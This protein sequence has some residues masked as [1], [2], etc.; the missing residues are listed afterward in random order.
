MKNIL[1][2]KIGFLC[3]V[4]GF[5]L[6]INTPKAS[7]A[8]C[9]G[10]QPQCDG[11]CVNPS[12]V[13]APDSYDSMGVPMTCH[14][15]LKQCFETVPRCDGDCP[16]NSDCSAQTFDNMGVPSSCFCRPRNQNN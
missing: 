9:N 2:K 15:I 1:I 11:S 13:C 8:A 5:C 4:L 14:C 7:A 16:P 3:L 6:L 10:T 12:E